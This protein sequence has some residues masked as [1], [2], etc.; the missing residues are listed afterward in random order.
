MMRGPAQILKSNGVY[1][2]VV[3]FKKQLLTYKVDEGILFDVGDL[4]K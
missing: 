3:F 2:N 4:I 1:I